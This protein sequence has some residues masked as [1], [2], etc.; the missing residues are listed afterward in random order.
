M[1]T[2]MFIITL[3][4]ST[5]IFGQNSHN[6][7]VVHADETNT[8]KFKYVFVNQ[9]GDTITR[10]DSSK[11]FI[12]FTDTAKYFAIVGIKHKHGWWAIDT[13]KNILFRVYNTSYGEPSPDEV[14]DGMIRIVDDSGKIGFADYKGKI[15]IQPQFEEASS[16]YNGKAIIGKQCEQILWKPL[17]GENDGDKHYSIECK[18]SGYID[19]N[20]QIKKIGNFTFE[21]IAKEIGWKSEDEW[22]K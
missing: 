4:S 6:F 12:C 20:G 5:I 11:Y 13:N 16:F 10:L 7:F 15:V 14:K 3:L 1:K 9:K 19:K 2:L 21:Q 18:Q 22:L 8:Q 17:Q